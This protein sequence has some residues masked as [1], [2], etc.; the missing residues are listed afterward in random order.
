MLYF[1]FEFQVFENNECTADNGNKIVIVLN[2]VG[3]GRDGD[4]CVGNLQEGHWPQT[5]CILVFLLVCLCA[6]VFMLVHLCK[7]VCVCV[8][9]IISFFKH[10]LFR[11]IHSI[12]I[13]CNCEA[14]PKNYLYKGLVIK[15]LRCCVISGCFFPYQ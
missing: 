2:S 8:C 1:Y 14:L 12:F 9:V 4:I 5:V 15:A 10:P 6:R 3:E 7:C 11:S 13:L